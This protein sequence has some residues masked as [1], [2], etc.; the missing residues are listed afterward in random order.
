MSTLWTASH[1]DSYL[2]FLEVGEINE[3][4]VVLEL[5]HERDLGHREVRGSNSR[6]KYPNRGREAWAHRRK[7]ADGI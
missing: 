2:G 6:K 7:C 3:V 4:F 5:A 1:R